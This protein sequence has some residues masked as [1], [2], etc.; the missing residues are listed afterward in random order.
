MQMYDGFMTDSKPS[1][2][3]ASGS[4]SATDPQLQQQIQR[5]YQLTVYGRWMLVGALWLGLAP[6]C[7]WGLRYEISLLLDY[8]T[9]TAVRYGIAYNRL[10][11]FGL[12]FCLGMTL[13]VATW[14]VRNRLLGLPSRER[15]RLVNQVIRIRRQGKSHPL[16]QWVCRQD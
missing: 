14:Q 9:W 16:W 12:A 10:P 7:L 13:S 3:V 11:A 4:S 5:L 8:F 6:L 1:F 2:D 15:K